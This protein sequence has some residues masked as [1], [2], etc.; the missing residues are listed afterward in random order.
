MRHGGMPR[1]RP[2]IL[3]VSA[4]AALVAGAR[5]VS[6]ITPDGPVSNAGESDDAEL[7]K[8]L[9]QPWSLGSSAGDA[10]TIGGDG[11]P[12]VGWSAEQP[13][14]LEL[15]HQLVDGVTAHFGAEAAMS[16]G[17]RRWSAGDDSTPRDR[18]ALGQLDWQA[19]AGLRVRLDEN[20]SAGVG[21]CWRSSRAPIGWD[22][23][24]NDRGD[25]SLDGEGV[26]WLSLRAEF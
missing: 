14:G 3:G 5:V 22:A 12:S 19:G 17:P 25:A 6:E 4:L 20:W 13:I 1:F 18:D 16:E 2:L 8:P 7:I 21:A 9:S 23:A 24:M 26:V 11:G 10:L 15:R